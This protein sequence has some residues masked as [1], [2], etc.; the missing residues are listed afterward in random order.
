LGPWVDI[1][2]WVLGYLEHQCKIISLLEG[3]VGPEKGRWVGRLFHPSWLVG[4]HLCRGQTVHHASELADVRPCHSDGTQAVA[5][6]SWKAAT[7]MLRLLPLAIPTAP[8]MSP[9]GVTCP[10]CLVEVDAV[11]VDHPQPGTL[12]RCLWAAAPVAG[13]GLSHGETTSKLTKLAR[14]SVVISFHPSF[15]QL[16]AP[17]SLQ[18]YPETVHWPITAPLHQLTPSVCHHGSIHPRTTHWSNLNEDNPL[19]APV[20][21]L[22][23][24]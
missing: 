11:H 2:N 8:L 9:T 4:C 21:L 7:G 15:D 22:I 5:D 20:V 19:F 13:E 16:G 6:W 24:P 12:E 14:T 23:S 17:S 1:L 18:G 3:C 10:P